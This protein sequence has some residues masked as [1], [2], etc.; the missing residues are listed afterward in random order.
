M[1]QILRRVA[2]SGLGLAFAA[3]FAF[4]G[5]AHAQ[6]DMEVEVVTAPMADT[7]PMSMDAH[8]QQDHTVRVGGV[9]EFIAANTEN[10]EDGFD[11]GRFSRIVVDY[12]NTLDNGL[13][14]AGQISY[15][16]NS[17]D[18]GQRPWAPDTLFISAGSG[19]G[20]V[21][22]GSHAM[23]LCSLHARA[24]ALVPG[25]WWA[26]Y[27]GVGFGAQGGGY[28]AEDAG[29]VVPTAISYAS[30][31]MG[32]L[33]A[34][35]S[36]APSYDAHQ[37]TNRAGAETDST[38]PTPSAEDALEAMVRYAANM[39]VADIAVS[40]GLQTAKDNALDSTVA[41]IQ[42]SFGGATVGADVFDS[43]SGDGYSVGAKYTLGALSPGI[44]Y[45]SADNDNGT[46]STYLTVGAAYQVGGGLS[47]WGEYQDIETTGGPSIAEDTVLIAGVA[48]S[49]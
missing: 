9:V 38:A 21:T 1:A 31:S 36:F 18:G 49:F 8:S 33:S 42:V 11:R 20:T 3:F 29:C 27:A 35:V 47:V 17:R 41:G 10:G 25:G 7:A 24:Y 14:V 45:S 5:S 19:F 28:F 12:S 16:V 4:A 43:A 13:V 37:W 26:G 34:M 39:G 44:A 22:F 15:M 46:E 30:P 23:A 2:V 6:D 48:I 32:G 40:A